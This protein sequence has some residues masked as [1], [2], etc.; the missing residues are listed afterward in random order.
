M[1]HTRVWNQTRDEF[2]ADVTDAKRILEDVTGSAVRG[3][4]AASWS[5]DERTPWVYSV[6]S[7]AGYKYSSSVYPIAH[8]HYGL[9]R[10]PPTPFHVSSTGMLEI[11]ATTASLAG[12]NWP[13]A[14]GGYFRL[15][16]LPVS[17]WLLRRARRQRGV[18]VVFYFHPWELDPDQ[19]RVAGADARTRFR[20]YVNLGKF[21]GRLQALLAS[22]EW[23]RM[24]RVFGTAGAV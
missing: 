17:L 15:L 13:A 19:P 14:G 6:L 5:F 2:R 9:P 12:R 8:D 23:D 11:P 1:R 18:P 21:E 3:Y 7:E 10:A 16:P 24:D 20:H 22:F 4:R